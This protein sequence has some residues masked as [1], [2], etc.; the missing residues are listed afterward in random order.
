MKNNNE[1]NDIINNIN[2]FRG[3]RHGFVLD[4]KGNIEEISWG[5]WATTNNEAQALSMCKFL[6]LS[7]DQ[8]FRK[9]MVVGEMTITL[10][11]ACSKPL[12]S[13]RNMSHLVKRILLEIKDFV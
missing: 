1:N 11:V 8:G 6:F 4:P 13:N 3:G 5:L 10:R 7:K 9:F 2:C 12:Q